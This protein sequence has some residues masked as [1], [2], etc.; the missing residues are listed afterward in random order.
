[1]TSVNGVLA[2]ANLYHSQACIAFGI[3]PIP[4]SLVWADML[5]LSSHINY[6]VCVCEIALMVLPSF[7][8]RRL[9]TGSSEN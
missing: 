6:E 8:L 4:D 5:I 3:T 2:S 1:M 9:L 7:G